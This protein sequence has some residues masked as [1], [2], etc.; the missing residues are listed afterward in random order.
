MPE[1]VFKFMPKI[2]GMLK[3]FYNSDSIPEV[4]YDVENDLQQR[5]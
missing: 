3:V 1:E 2:L 5:H 4:Q